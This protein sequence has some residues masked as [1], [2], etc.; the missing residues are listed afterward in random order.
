M[1]VSLSE[2]LLCRAIQIEYKAW[3]FYSRWADHL[4]NRSGRRKM[5][6]LSRSEG[7]HKKLL[8]RR[9]RVLLGRDYVPSADVDDTADEGAEDPTQSGAHALVDQAS[10]LE[11]V[12]FAIG[13]EERA[14]DF[15]SAELNKVDD[16]EDVRMLK[17]LV[18]L[19]VIHKDRLQREFVR[20]N[21]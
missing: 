5:T 9:H 14:I 18:R 13:M 16:P 21:R 4:Q 10:A 12:S 17:S 2:E 20:L 7:Q 6:A 19:E 8:E 11:V 3:E 15:Y 1:V